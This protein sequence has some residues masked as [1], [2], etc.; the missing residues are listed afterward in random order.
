MLF[1]TRVTLYEP[2]KRMNAMPSP[3]IAHNMPVML[4]MTVLVQFIVVVKT[5]NKC[6]EP[7]LLAIL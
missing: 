4:A 7:C 3:L 5:P 2:P 6:E 1:S